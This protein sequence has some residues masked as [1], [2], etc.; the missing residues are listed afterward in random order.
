M[1]DAPAFKLIVLRSFQMDPRRFRRHR[2]PASRGRASCQSSDE[3]GRH[4]GSKS[5]AYDF[6]LAVIDV[7]AGITDD[8]CFIERALSNIEKSVEQRGKPR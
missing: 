2:L 6:R 8:S 7:W 3:S 4:D 5:H 1:T